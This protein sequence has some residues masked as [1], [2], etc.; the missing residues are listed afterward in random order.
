MPPRGA[1]GLVAATTVVLG[2]VPVLAAAPAAHAA[3]KRLVVRA[4]ESIQAAVDRAAPGDDIYVEPGVYRGSVQITV[5]RLTL[6][7]AGP[8]T[9]IAPSAAGTENACA[10]AGHG[11]CVTGTADH[12]A[13][14]VRL[15][16]LT[17]AGFKKNGV[18]A[19]RADRIEVR[20]LTARDNG[21][22]GIS[23]EQSVQGRFVGNESENNGESG[24]F[25]ANYVNAEGGALDTDGALVRDNRLVGNRIGLVLRRLRDLVVEN[26]HI[27]DNCGGVFVV[28]DEGR[29]QAGDLTVRRNLVAENNHY[30]VSPANHGLPNIQGVGILLT[31]AADVLVEGNSVLGNVSTGTAGTATGPALKASPMAGGIVLYASNAPG[32]HNT[33]NTIRNNLALGNAPA[34]LAD[35]DSGGSGSSGSSG[36]TLA[37]NTFTGNR[38]HISEPTGWC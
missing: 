22:Q 1:I 13:N 20:G 23:L 37:A 9:V 29:P 15:G 36:T 33:G 4:G 12:R 14:D 28:G 38:C 30:C 27:T 2:L 26:N 10:R 5:P 21:Q 32:T 35:R 34:D 18:N 8:G 3:P 25:I 16:H 24:I 19:T 31:G 11:L 7:G 17:V 6:R